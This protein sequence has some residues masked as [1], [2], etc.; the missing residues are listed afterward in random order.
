[1]LVTAP[2]VLL[3][4]DYGPSAGSASAECGAAAPGRGEGAVF[5]LA[6]ISSV[7]T[8]RVQHAGGAATL[9][10][11]WESAGDERGGLVCQ[12]SDQNRPAAGAGGVLPPPRYPV[13]DFA[14]SGRRARLLWPPLPWL[15]SQSGWCRDGA[16]RPGVAV[17]WF[18]FG[19]TLVPVI[20]LVQ[21]GL[22]G[23]ARP[24]HLH[25]PH[26]PLHRRGLGGGGPVGRLVP[27]GESD[28]APRGRWPVGP[29]AATDWAAIALCSVILAGWGGLTFRQTT[30]WRTDLLLFQ[31]AL[32]VT[33]DTRW[34][35]STSHRPR[36]PRPV[37]RGQGPL[38]GGGY[39]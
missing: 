6:A 22:H 2:F 34:R 5:L 38:P 29:R 32:A 30:F 28:A 18:W 25:P 20:G 31:H 19:G 15:L 13:S 3:L 33:G 9:A 21:V 39:G 26:W 27:G 4:V 23:Y 8:F 16:C 12:V 11:P 36:G 7:I 17:G 14:T 24:V 35:I 37:R 1:M 10:L